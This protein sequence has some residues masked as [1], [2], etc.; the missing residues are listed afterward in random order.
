MNGPEGE[1]GGPGAPA[2]KPAPKAA[3][4]KDKKPEKKDGKKPEKKESKPK[5]KTS[6]AQAVENSVELYYNGAFQLEGGCGLHKIATEFRYDLDAVSAEFMLG[7]LGVT[8]SEAKHKVAEARKLNGSDSVKLAGL[9][10]ITTLGERYS[11]SVK[12]ASA[13]LSRLPDLR[14]D[15]IKEAAAIRDEGTVDK[16]LALNFI[17]P[18]NVAT[19]VEYLPE[20]EQAGEKMAEML[21]HSYLGQQDMPESAIE[22]AMN[23]ME[24]V[25]SGLK[26]IRGIESATT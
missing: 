14:R 2:G 21:I 12:T 8:G 6:A 10:T 7:L 18:E 11:Q 1:A 19:F 15:L 16:I 20:L 17:N 13:F 9:K 22:R 23:G 26:A 5:S 24:E 4:K 3:P 25:V